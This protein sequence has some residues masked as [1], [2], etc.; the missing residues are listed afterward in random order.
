MGSG[1]MTETE[2][3]CHK[4]WHEAALSRLEKGGFTDMGEWTVHLILFHH[5]DRPEMLR[6]PSERYRR[7]LG[8]ARHKLGLPVP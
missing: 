4:S 2:R 6:P 8:D 3:E 7:Y 5:C 1:G